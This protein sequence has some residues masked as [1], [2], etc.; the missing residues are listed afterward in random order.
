MPSHSFLTDDQLASML[1]YVRKNF[2]HSTDEIT[3]EEV[4][5]QRNKTV[6]TK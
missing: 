4:S 5:A 3:P 6:T 2:G 1:S